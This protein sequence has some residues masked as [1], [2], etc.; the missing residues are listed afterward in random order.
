M[1]ELQ[2]ERG[3]SDRA[4]VDERDR[5]A[6]A[7]YTSTKREVTLRQDDFRE[8]LGLVDALLAAEAA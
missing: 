5:A 6:T 8:A 7:V 2:A 3:A 4:V 1:G